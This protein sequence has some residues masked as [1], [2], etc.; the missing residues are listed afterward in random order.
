MFRGDGAE[1]VPKDEIVAVG[2]LTQRDLERLGDRF[3]GAIPVH[4]DG[5]FDDLLAKL[6]QI[7]VEPLGKG[8]VLIPRTKA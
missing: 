2:L 8:V 7:D 6:D 3:R 4:P 1:R 5:M